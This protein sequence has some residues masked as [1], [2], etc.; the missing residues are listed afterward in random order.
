MRDIRRD[1]RERL[2][3]VGKERKTLQ[4]RLAE[5]DSTEAGIKALLNR[6]ERDFGVQPVQRQ[7]PDI[8]P[9]QPN[10]FGYTPLSK[11]ILK[12]ARSNQNRWLS[13]ADFKQAAADEHFDFGEQSPGRTLHWALVGL[14]A[15]GHLESEG[16]DKDRKYRLKEAK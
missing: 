2:D 12:I 15:N 13:L 14:T 6:E 3:A 5:L 4:A 16:T 1:L 7:L 9:D 8:V 10:G 11:L